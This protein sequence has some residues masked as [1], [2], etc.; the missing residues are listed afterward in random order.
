MSTLA[1]EIDL[2]ERT[3]RTDEEL[4]VRLFEQKAEV[5]VEKVQLLYS[6]SLPLLSTRLK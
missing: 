1:E 2:L 3:I 6:C 4:L 5:E